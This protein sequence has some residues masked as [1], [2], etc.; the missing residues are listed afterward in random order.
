V[1]SLEVVAADRLD[2]VAVKDVLPFNRAFDERLARARRT[3]QDKA[4]A[5]LEVVADR[6]EHL[7]GLLDQL[8]CGVVTPE[9]PFRF[10]NALGDDP[11]DLF[12]SHSVE[13]SSE[14]RAD[15]CETGGHANAPSCR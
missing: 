3:E 12:S 1:R 10:A 11:F 7:V 13:P 2:V 9:G 15:G 6:A 8:E 4:P 5:V 14:I